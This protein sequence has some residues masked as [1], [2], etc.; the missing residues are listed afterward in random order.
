MKFIIICATLLGS[1]LAA[2]V[3]DE[4]RKLEETYRTPGGLVKLLPDGVTLLPVNYKE[5]AA[6]TVK[7]FYT[8]EGTV[9]KQGVRA[10]NQ[11]FLRVAAAHTIV[12]CM[13]N[14]IVPLSQQKEKREVGPI[15]SLLQAMQLKRM[16]AILRQ[17]EEAIYGL[18]ETIQPDA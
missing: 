15:A 10:D 13:L 3:T 16:G 14:G 18:Y 4:L 5:W 8:F 7:H 9:V 2:S 1:F 17:L 6:E 12:R 11:D